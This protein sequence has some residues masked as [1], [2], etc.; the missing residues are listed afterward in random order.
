MKFQAMGFAALGVVLGFALGGIPA[1]RELRAMRAERDALQ[2][3]LEALERPDLL[4]TLLPVLSGKDAPAT[5]AEPAGTP[6]TNGAPGRSASSQPAADRPLPRGDVAVIGAREGSSP[7]GTSPER[8]ANP[9]SSAAA[10][11][12]DS[13]RPPEGERRQRTPAE[14]LSRFDD[15]AAA[16]RARAAAARATLIEQTNLNPAQL[17]QVDAAVSDMN[18][19]LTKQGEKVVAKVATEKEP[20]PATLLELSHEVSGILHEAQTKLDGTLGEGAEAVD[21]SARRI[22]NYVDIEPWRPFVEQELARRE[23]GAASA[24]GAAGAGAP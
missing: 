7:D 14:M 21:A 23:Q 15:F 12:R 4:R 18:K 22:W 16:Q 11:Q 13:T 1:R 24:T 5:A 20:E 19:K 2:T 9:A 8:R 6:Q 3:Q 17:A 10:A